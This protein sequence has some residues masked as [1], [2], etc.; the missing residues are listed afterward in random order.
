MRIGINYVV[1]HETPEEWAE[2]LFNKGYRATIFP[3][4]YQAPVSKIDAYVRAA[5]DRDILIAEVGV[6]NSPHLLDKVAAAKA[7]DFA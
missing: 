2:I 1:P 4:N 7:Q 3:V 5:K 6:W